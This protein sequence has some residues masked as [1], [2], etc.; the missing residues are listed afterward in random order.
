MTFGR[1]ITYFLVFR[2]IQQFKCLEKKM[3]LYYNL[4]VGNDPEKQYL[5]LFLHQALIRQHY[6]TFGH[7]QYYGG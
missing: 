2:L 1:L 6:S 7:V 5:Q 4:N 3:K